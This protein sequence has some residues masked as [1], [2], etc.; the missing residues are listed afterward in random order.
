MLSDK[1]EGS[2]TGSRVCANSVSFARERT[3]IGALQPNRFC[4]ETVAVF[5][6]RNGSEETIRGLPKT[7]NPTHLQGE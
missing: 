6:C 1:N 5:F 2:D 7:G 3:I 4:F